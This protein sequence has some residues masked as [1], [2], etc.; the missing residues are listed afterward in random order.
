MDPART[1]F[2][3]LAEEFRVVSAWTNRG[4]L[5]STAFCRH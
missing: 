2:P 1:F 4:A 3:Q 5:A